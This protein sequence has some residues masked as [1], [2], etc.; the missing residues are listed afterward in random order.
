MNRLHKVHSDSSFDRFSSLLDR[1]ADFLIHAG[2]PVR[3]ATPEKARSLFSALEASH[4]TRIISR[5]EIEIT[6]FEEIIAAGEKLTDSARFVWR[7]FTKCGGS[8]SSDIFGKIHEGDVVEIYSTEQIHL[9]QNLNFFDWVSSTLES[10]FCEPWFQTTKRD[11]EA[12]L[13]IYAAALR[14]ITG[15]VRETLD[16][17]VPWHL[18]EEIDTEM[19]LK[20]HLRLKWI[21]PVFKNQQLESIIAISECKPYQGAL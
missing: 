19:N 21:S 2:K 18:I 15:E 8:P 10:I 11:S 3:R 7:Y 9:F 12:Q 13:L 14:I 17:K 16:P 20:F 5:L 6:L 4:K 1:Y